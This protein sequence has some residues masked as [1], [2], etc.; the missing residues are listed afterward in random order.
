MGVILRGRNGQ[1]GIRQLRQARAF[2]ASYLDAEPSEVALIG[3]GA[4]SCCFGFRRGDEELAIRFGNYVDD[5]RKDQLAAAYASPDL[6]IPEVLDVGQAFDGYYRHLQAGPRS[7]AGESQ[8]DPM[9]RD[10]PFRRVGTG[11]H[12]H[13]RFVIFFGLRRLGA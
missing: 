4:W 11:S 2:L 8:F 7:P 12:A 3:E 13:D 1:N 6:P 9:A 10:C 5:F